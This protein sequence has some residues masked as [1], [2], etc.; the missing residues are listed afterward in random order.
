MTDYCTMAAV[1]YQ[2]ELIFVTVRLESPFRGQLGLTKIDDFL[3][4]L[5]T[6]I[7]TEENQPIQ[8]SI[9]P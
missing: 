3:I 6:E 2:M 5:S 1:S 4:E 9:P 8:F 7:P